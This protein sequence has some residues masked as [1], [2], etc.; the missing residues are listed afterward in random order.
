MGFPALDARNPPTYPRS[1]AV[2]REFVVDVGMWIGLEGPMV[3][4]S[5]IRRSLDIGVG[6]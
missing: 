1:H 6:G 2:G 4:A 5:D 3:R